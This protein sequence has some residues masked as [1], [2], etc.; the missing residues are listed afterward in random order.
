MERRPAGRLSVRRLLLGAERQP[1]DDC[2]H[3][4]RVAPGVGL[5]RAKVEGVSRGELVDFAADFEL[6]ATGDHEEQLFAGVVHRLGAYRDRVLATLEPLGLKLGRDV[7]EVGSVPES[8]IAAWYAAADVLAFPSVKEGF[9]LAALEA[10][11]AGV[12]VVTSDLPVFREWMVPGRDALFAPVG[13]AR[14]L[15]TALGEVLDD[16]EL[17]ARLVEAGRRLADQHSWEAS[18]RRHLEVYAGVPA[19]S[20]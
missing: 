12:P 15:A 18:A 19:S 10:M 17:R 16:V 2:I 14:A 5:L 20:P 8:E 13:D 7:V 11:A 6:E 9:G 1:D 4:V 3:V